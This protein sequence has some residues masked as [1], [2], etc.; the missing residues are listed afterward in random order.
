MAKGDGVN[1]LQDIANG[2][3]L[4]YQPALGVEALIT[5]FAVENQT[6]VTVRL[7]NGSLGANSFVQAIISA[8]GSSAPWKILINNTNYLR[9]SN[10]SGANNEIGFTGVQ[11][12]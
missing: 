3:S 11:T 5:E 10:G 7:Y 1:D 6:S 4:D 8:R 9:I 2:A 12:K